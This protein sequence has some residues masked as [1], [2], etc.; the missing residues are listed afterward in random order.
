MRYGWP[1]IPIAQ[2]RCSMTLALVNAL[3]GG[4]DAAATALGLPVQKDTEG[5]RLMRKMSRGARTRVSI[6]RSNA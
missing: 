3:P 6:A 5:Y 2:Q 4:L 1:Q